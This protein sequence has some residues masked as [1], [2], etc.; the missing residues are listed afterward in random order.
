MGK[1]KYWEAKVRMLEKTASDGLLLMPRH[2]TKISSF[3]FLHLLWHTSRLRKCLLAF[4]F[5]GSECNLLMH[6]EEMH[7]KKKLCNFHLLF[8]SVFSTS[9][10]VVTPMISFA[11]V[12]LSS[13]YIPSESCMFSE[14]DPNTLSIWRQ[15]SSEL[16]TGEEMEKQWQIWAKKLRLAYPEEK[17]QQQ[18]EKKVGCAY[19]GYNLQL[20]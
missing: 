10:S 6:G 7:F 17:Q 20:F 13:V 8:T 11:C 14:G 18:N 5:W 4:F 3:V 16:L 9:S 15:F 12:R 1:S 2:K 19:L